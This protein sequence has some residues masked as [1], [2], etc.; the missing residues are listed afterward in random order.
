MS[1]ATKIVVA[2]VAF[3]MGIDKADVRVVI[4]MT[5]PKSIEAY[6]QETGRAGRDG[7][8]SEALLYYSRDDSGKF[9]F[10]QVQSR[11]KSLVSYAQT[12]LLF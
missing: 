5:L 7:L 6:Y 10:L 2:T 11:T 3:G 4:H 12:S 1:G 8:P 9:K